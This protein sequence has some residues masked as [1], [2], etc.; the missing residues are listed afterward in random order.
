MRTKANPSRFR[1]RVSVALAA[2]GTLAL[3]VTAGAGDPPSYS[4]TLIDM[5]EGDFANTAFAINNAGQIAGFSNSPTGHHAWR[6][7]AGVLEDI[8][9]VGGPLAYCGLAGYG[10]ASRWR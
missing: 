2:V 3:R 10:M 9:S 5:F 6:W 4:L 1:Q 7:T 8:G